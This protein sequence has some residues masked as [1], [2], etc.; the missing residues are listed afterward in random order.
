MAHMFL[1]PAKSVGRR[2]G[3]RDH[4]LLRNCGSYVLF[5]CCSSFVLHSVFCISEAHEMVVLMVC[6][7]P[8]TASIKLPQAGIRKYDG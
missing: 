7:T 8:L 1:Y 6:D 4:I 2:E 3:N 5:S